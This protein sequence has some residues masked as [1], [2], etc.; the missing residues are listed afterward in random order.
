MLLVR[1]ERKKETFE[2]QLKGQHRNTRQEITV[3]MDYTSPDD[4]N[5]HD[6]Y[7]EEFE[8]LEGL[9][10]S[11]HQ[12]GLLSDSELELER[13]S[14]GLS[15][16]HIRRKRDKFYGIENR[17]YTPWQHRTSELKTGQREGELIVYQDGS[18]VQV[19]REMSWEIEEIGGKRGKVVGFSNASRR[20]M[21]RTLAK[22]QASRKPLW[23]DLT[24]P[25]EFYSERYDGKTLKE[26]HLK[27]FFQRLH[28]RYP[29]AGI[30]WKLE[31]QY[32]K[33]G[34][35]VGKYFPHFHVLL[36]GFHDQDIFQLRQ[37]FLRMWWEACGKLS[38]DHLEA[39]IRLTRLR[40]TRG[41]FWYASKYMSKTVE[42]MQ[43]FDIDAQAVGRWWGI[44]GREN[45]PFS[46]CQIMTF[47]EDEH[48]QKIIRWMAERA[49]FSDAAQAADWKGL[50]IFCD[51]EKFF[52]QDLDKLLQ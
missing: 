10:D 3:H 7:F 9:L 6:S 35:H 51:A 12:G 36:W 27:K 34:K 20:R 25:D 28:Y 33:S 47:F 16:L 14:S 49:G 45:L 21:M 26:K 52:Y 4:Q 50:T 13:R 32:R 46:I 43:D 48:L 19:K 18:L 44:K 24:Y 38:Q 2:R 41:A 30:I 40:S 17:N 8:A 15:T 23:L 11:L 5:V 42:Q 37:D 31:Y 29:E 22:I 1:P 39:G